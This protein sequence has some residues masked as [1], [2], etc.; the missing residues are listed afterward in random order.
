MAWD[1]SRIWLLTPDGERKVIDGG[2]DGAPVSRS[3]R[4]A[5]FSPDGSGWRTSRTGVAGGTS[6]CT[7]RP[8]ASGASLSTTR[9]SRARPT[10]GPG[11]MR[12]AWSPDGQQIAV[13]RTEA[14]TSGV[15]L[16]SVGRAR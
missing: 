15:Y 14:G 2:R 6:G 11:G 1:A 5:R 9:P 8:A 13:I 7:T 3:R 4:P 16:V 10:W 12:F